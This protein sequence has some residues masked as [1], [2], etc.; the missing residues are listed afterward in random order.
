VPDYTEQVNHR[1]AEES[2]FLPQP[3]ADDQNPE[4]ITTAFVLECLAQNERGDGTLYAHL[5]RDQVVYVK[6]SQEW[7]AF[8]G[9]YWEQDI[10]DIHLRNVKSVTEKYLNEATGL[11]TPIQRVGDQLRDVEKRSRL[12]N[13]GSAPLEKP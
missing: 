9:H 8:K 4:E 3:P 12:P 10:F 1:I 11:K 6:K 13:T 2:E 5:H 7:L